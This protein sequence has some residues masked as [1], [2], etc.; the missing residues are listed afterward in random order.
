MLWQLR[1]YLFSISRLY[2]SG[3]LRDNMSH[4]YRHGQG[5]VNDSFSDDTLGLAT[6][7]TFRRDL[8][9]YS[10]HPGYRDSGVMPPDSLYDQRQHGSSLYSQSSYNTSSPFFHGTLPKNV[11]QRSDWV[12]API[13]L[14]D[15]SLPS[16]HDPMWTNQHQYPPDYGLP[17]QRGQIR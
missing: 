6:P 4:G 7:P 8:R 14:P 5:S 1:N 10:E 12:A 3:T 2:G 9:L 13:R 16:H 17:L 11:N 15:W